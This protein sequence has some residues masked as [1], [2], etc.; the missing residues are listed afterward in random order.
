[1][2]L[3]SGGTRRLRGDAK[4]PKPRLDASRGCIL[5]SAVPG[6]GDTLES[7]VF[8]D[9]DGTVYLHDW[10]RVGIVKTT[11]QTHFIELKQ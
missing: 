7:S 10:N 5:A 4:H 8:A 11:I 1:M 9:A 3:T 6:P 2:N